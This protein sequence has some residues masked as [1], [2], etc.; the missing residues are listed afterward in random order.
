MH[1]IGTLRVEG[2]AEHEL[3]SRK[4]RTT[5]RLLAIASGAPVSADRIASV[6]WA[7]AEQP[8]DPPAQV[9][10]IVSRLR[11]VL[12]PERI[13]HGDAGYT[14]HADWLDLTAAA[15]LTAEAERRIGAR[16]PAAA[17]A[18]ALAARGLLTVARLD[19]DVWLE[20]ERLAVGR[21][22]TRAGHLVARTALLAGDLATGVEVAEQLVAL[23]P[24][25]E[26]ALRL[27]MAGLSAQGR[28]SSALALHER[29]R[30]RLADD[31]GVSPSRETDA[32]HLA[33]LKGLPVP[34]I[35]VTAR[36]PR[37]P[38]TGAGQLFDR[39]EQLATLDRLFQRAAGAGP[40]VAVVEGEPG[41]GKTALAKAWIGSL[42]L[43]RAR[44]R[45]ALRSAQP[46]AAAAT[47]G[48]HAAVV[49]PWCGVR[50]CARSPWR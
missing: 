13:T 5:L 45:H 50:R 47:R 17:L 29:I 43:T 44:A 48:A 19:D 15:E 20:H 32:A 38:D 10:V 41:A 27:A 21:L 46:H 22:A 30:A 40:V 3:G 11:R 31:L 34:G 16:N 49:P 35:D 25:D 2:F 36:V 23:D 9:A 42:Q 24:Y 7:D 4:A 1:V 12:G 39:S 33:V 18:A 14:L 6:L 8:R 28:A 26:E 37:A